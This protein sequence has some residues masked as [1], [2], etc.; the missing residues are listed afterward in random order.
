MPKAFIYW[1]CMFLWLVA[2][3]GWAYYRTR[4]WSFA[5]GGILLFIMLLLIGLAL[6]GDPIK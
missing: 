4:D 6:F 5:P 3:F 2:D 1:L